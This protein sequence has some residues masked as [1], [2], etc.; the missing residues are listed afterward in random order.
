VSTSCLLAGHF[1][2]PPQAYSSHIRIPIDLPQCL[3]GLL[4]DV[5]AEH[6]QHTLIIDVREQYP[7]V[8]G[9]YLACGV[10]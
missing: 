9:L 5:P 6:A 2:N 4:T 10:N 3:N 1:I 8:A 7:W